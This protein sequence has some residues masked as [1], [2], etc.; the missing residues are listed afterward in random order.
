MVLE[1]TEWMDWVFGQADPS[2]WERLVRLDGICGPDQSTL[3][4]LVEVFE[5]PAILLKPY[6]DELV[7]QALW[8]LAATPSPLCTTSPSTGLCATA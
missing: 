2:D 4:R 7:N 8:D 1:L 6:S 5:S 3:L